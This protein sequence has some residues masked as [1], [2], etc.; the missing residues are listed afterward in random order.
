[1]LLTG[2]QIFKSFVEVKWAGDKVQRQMFWLHLG[3]RGDGSED[4]LLI[5]ESDDDFQA[6]WRQ[7]VRQVKSNSYSRVTILF[8]WHELGSL[9]YR[10][11]ASD[12][13]VYIYIEE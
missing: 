6:Q 4:G 13:N 1:L 10:F 11:P 2:N 9:T 8:Y 3:H 12:E 5:L 7:V